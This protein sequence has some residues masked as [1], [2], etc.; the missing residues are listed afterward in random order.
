MSA[1]DLE[2]FRE[3]L[4]HFTTTGEILG[5]WYTPD[6]VWD[7]STFTGWPEKQRYPGASGVREF[8]ALWLEAWED[9]RMEI[10]E[11]WQASDGRI[12]VEA[13]QFGRS[14]STGLDVS[15]TYAMIWT[16]RDGKSAWMQMFSSVEEAL[17]AGGLAEPPS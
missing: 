17:E 16:L 4:R 5:E 9:W 8:M 10:G 1:E 7:M 3:R 6:F 15:M 12:V 14:K 2:L 13:Q 11:L